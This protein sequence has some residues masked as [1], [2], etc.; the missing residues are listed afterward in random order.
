MPGFLDA[1]MRAVA[2]TLIEEFGMSVTWTQY[3]DTQSPTSG[4]VDRTAAYHTVTISPPTGPSQLYQPGQ[5][6]E[7]GECDVMLAASAIVFV[8]KVGDEVDI[9][10]QT[11]TATQVEAYYSGTLVAA[12]KATVRR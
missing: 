3:T 6:I 5:V 8:P 4:E 9:D 7:Q 11:F 2:E 12:Y 10:G 1:K